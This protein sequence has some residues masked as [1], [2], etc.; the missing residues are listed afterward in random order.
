M[1]LRRMGAAGTLLLLALPAATARA[2]EPDSGP[3]VR[4][5]SAGVV[6]VTPEPEAANTSLGPSLLS[7]ALPGAG[8]Y[9]EGH[10]RAW[11]YLALE[12][13]AWTVHLAEQAQ[14]KRYRTR[15]RDFAWTAARIQSGPRQD[16][17]WSYYEVL[18][19]WMRSG[20]YDRD[21]TQSGLQPETDAT[22]FNGSIWALA[23]DI[24]FPPGQTVAAGDPAYTRALQY[25][26]ER[27]YGPSFLWD[28]SSDP[29]AQTRYAQLI[30]KSDAGFRHA[31]I[32]LGAV[33]ANHLISAADAFLTGRSPESRSHAFLRPDLTGRGTRWTAG[34][35]IPVSR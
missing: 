10:T 22:T 35:R 11:A 32:A 8:Q 14:G 4:V 6:P 24:Y 28:W 18:T 25:Y 34:F 19:H 31:T 5:H 16:G 23:R 17:D 29:A 1:R 7:L 9:R 3:I 15:Y 21:R 13:A 26:E 33:F 27:A 12:A 2:Q 30:D 20:A